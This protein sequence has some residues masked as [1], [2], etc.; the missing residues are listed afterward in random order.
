VPIGDSLEAHV[1]EKGTGSVGFLWAQPG[2]PT[3][4]VLPDHGSIALYDLMGNPVSAT[5]A[6]V[7]E[8]PIYFTSEDEVSTCGRWLQAA[9]ARN[10]SP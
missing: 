2:Q 7:E 1:Y 8:A 4:F 10:R 9:V 6:R 3:S 5:P